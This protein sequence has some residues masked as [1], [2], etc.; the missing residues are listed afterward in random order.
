LF[1]QVIIGAPF[2]TRA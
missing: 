1:E 2:C